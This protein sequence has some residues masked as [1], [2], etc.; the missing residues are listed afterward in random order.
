MAA[1]ALLEVEGLAAE[2]GGRTLFRQLA[3]AL[4]PGRVVWLR[5]ANGRGKTTLLRM[6]AGL[7]SPADGAIRVEGRPLDAEARHRLLW[8][9]HANA[10]A[11]EL[12]VEEALAFLA[13]LAGRPADADTLAAALARLGLA[14]RRRAF[15]RTLSQG[16]RRRAALARLALPAP[17]PVWLL[18]EPY[19]ALDTEGCQTLH[20]LLAEHAARG[21]SALVTSHVVP[22]AGT[23][24]EV[25]DLDRFAPAPRR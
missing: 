21:G 22:P 24:G 8:L 7:A 10:L 4:P 19:D 13:R 18:D 14:K 17:P 5:G 6:L 9:G 1:A 15:V 20:A 2:R 23:D 12:R 3:F 11:G 16:Q 25:L